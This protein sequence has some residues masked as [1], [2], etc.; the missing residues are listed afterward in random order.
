MISLQLFVLSWL[1]MMLSSSAAVDVTIIEPLYAFQT[2]EDKERV[3]TQPP[4]ILPSWAVPAIEGV[5]E[6]V[7]AAS[8]AVTKAAK[9]AKESLQSVV[10]AGASAD[11]DKVQPHLVPYFARGCLPPSFDAKLLPKWGKTLMLC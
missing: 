7:Q 11:I 3:P 4:G 2:I 10:A 5:P 9:D 6:A 1:A 8:K